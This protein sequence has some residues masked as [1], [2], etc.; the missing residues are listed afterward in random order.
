MSLT[1]LD[2]PLERLGIN[3]N[4]MNWRDLWSP[5]EQYYLN[6]VVISPLN[7]AS[8]ILN[9]RTALVGGNDPTLNPEWI[10]LSATTTGVIQVNAGN[11][12]IVITGT[13]TNPFV[14]NAGVISLLATNGVA[15]TGTAQN[16]LLENTGVVS[17]VQGL[18]ISV[19]ATFPRTPTINNT[20]IR[21]LA[22]G[23]GISI[24]AGSNPSI[25]NTGVISVVQG[26]G[27][28]VSAGQTP[29]ISNTGVVGVSSGTGITVDNT[30][31]QLPSVNNNGVL[32]VA[33]G[34]GISVDNTNPQLPI[35]TNTL[36]RSRLSTLPVG[37][38]T[39]G[40][41]PM[42]TTAFN[43]TTAF[44]FPTTIPSPTPPL[45]AIITD[46]S[47]GTPPAGVWVLDLTGFCFAVDPIVSIT[48]T[49]YLAISLQRGAN[50]YAVP[51]T[52]GGEV[53]LIGNSIPRAV[54]YIA[55]LGKIIIDATIVKPLLGG[56][57]Q[58][59]VIQNLTTQ[60]IFSCSYPSVVPCEFFPFGI[61]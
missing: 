1:P 11:A 29:T 28:S 40:T 10:E 43:D 20:G 6:D 51:S 33:G 59:I 12:G 31:P 34:T 50:L 39:S 5:T 49:S 18:G 38:P 24:S 47:I 48:L 2:N 15:N 56:M 35:I 21:T 22:Q 46:F 58:Q 53:N 8:Y 4:G 36:P 14:N 37:F 55:T 7:N 30:N 52:Q 9:G 27:I 16:V 3:P 61:E 13:A 60:D 57:F 42:Q 54:P 32:T 26:T 25:S 19:D 41:I 45:N 44:P 23:A 17:L